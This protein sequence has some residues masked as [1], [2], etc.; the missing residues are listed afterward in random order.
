M[1]F[2]ENPAHIFQCTV[3]PPPE[4][5]IYYYHPVF[6]IKCDNLG[7]LDF[8][9][10]RL[11]GFDISGWEISFDTKG[12]VSVS[13]FYDY[14]TSLEQFKELFPGTRTVGASKSL[15]I[16][17]RE[18]VAYEC[19]TQRRANGEHVNY[20]N[21]N[22]WDLRKDNLF[23][24]NEVPARYPYRESWK[25]DRALFLDES[26]R[27]INKRVLKLNAIGYNPYTYL[28][29][30][31]RL[32]PLVITHWEKHKEKFGLQPGILDHWGNL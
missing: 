22:P 3:P 27:E 5:F 8:D 7:I 23:T 17:P 1:K 11:E 4:E 19:Y 18:R 10:S 12:Q 28:R 31:L 32:P 25:Q 29:L 20:Y 30:M 9:E 13:K 21:N 2:V 24:T 26:A 16:G 14:N 15:Y 6:P